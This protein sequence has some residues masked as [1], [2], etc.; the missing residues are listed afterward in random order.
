[1][2]F[3]IGFISGIVFMAVLRTVLHRLNTRAYDAYMEDLRL[4][5]ELNG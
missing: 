2:M 3:T 5:G 4:K 1:M